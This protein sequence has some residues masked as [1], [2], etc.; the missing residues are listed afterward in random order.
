MPRS[1]LPVPV[2]VDCGENIYDS[3]SRKTRCRQCAHDRRRAKE[4]RRASKRYY[5]SKGVST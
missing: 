1:V 2:C 5:S 3:T 4:I